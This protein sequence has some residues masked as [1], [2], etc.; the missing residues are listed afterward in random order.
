MKTERH[1]LV[2][3]VSSSRGGVRQPSSSPRC[4][5]VLLQCPRVDLTGCAELLPAALGCSVGPDTRV[6]AEAPAVKPGGRQSVCKVR[7][8]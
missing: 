1:L 5:Q 8:G 4:A 6:L 7:S 3:V 2:S